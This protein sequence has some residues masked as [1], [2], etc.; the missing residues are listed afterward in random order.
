LE[1]QPRVGEQQADPIELFE[2]QQDLN[3]L[4]T[5]MSLK[6][7][8]HAEALHSKDERIKELEDKL[9]ATESG[10]PQQR[11]SI[12][13]LHSMHSTIGTASDARTQGLLLRSNAKIQEQEAEIR[14]LR[15][16][17]QE[18]ANVEIVEQKDEEIKNLG[19]QISD[20]ETQMKGM[21]EEHE[22]ALKQKDETIQF[23]QTQLVEMQKKMPKP[24]A[25]TRRE[26]VGEEGTMTLG[27]GE[28]SEEEGGGLWGAISAASPGWLGGGQAVDRRVGR[29]APHS[30]K[31]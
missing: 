23:F 31:L 4:K 11:E 7:E 10:K 12:T 13:S 8:Q 25:Y 15:Q 28:G 9:E 21:E 19:V 1:A 24:A 20:L 14:E 17:L 3:Q 30:P 27:G 22:N 2:L 29:G 16:K 6:E 5:D 26:N 18:L